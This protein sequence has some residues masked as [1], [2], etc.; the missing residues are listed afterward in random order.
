MQKNKDKTKLIHV[1]NTINIGGMENGVINI[2]NALDREKFAPP[3]I[4]CI[5]NKGQMADRFREDVKL[6]EMNFYGRLYPIYICKLF[7]L[8]RKEQA[9]IVHTHGWGAGSH[10]GIL[11]AKLARIPV[12]INGEHGSFFT[13]KNQ[14]IIQKILFYACN[15]NLSVSETLK[16]KGADILKVPAKKIIVIKNGVDIDKFTGNYNRLCVRE[17]LKKAY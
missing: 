5:W 7:F 13:K 1:V 2:C 11:A 10:I 4:C 6:V 17:E 16:Y 9:D 3:I 15:Y 14:L 8:F 12:I